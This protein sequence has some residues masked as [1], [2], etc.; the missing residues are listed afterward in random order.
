[1]Q[2]IEETP[3]LASTSKITPA[4]EVAASTEAATAKATNLECTLSDIDK[5]LL[6][7]DAEE[8]A[9]SVEEVLVSCRRYFERKRLQFSKYNWSRIIQG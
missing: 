5:V 6:D 3:P 2:A 1:M 4:A 8:T 7:L 9:T